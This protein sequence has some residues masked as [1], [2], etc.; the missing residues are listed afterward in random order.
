MMNYEFDKKI[1]LVCKYYELEFKNYYKDNKNILVKTFSAQCRNKTGK[2][3]SCYD[4]SRFEHIYFGTCFLGV[5]DY[6]VSH[7]KVCLSWVLSEEE[8]KRFIKIGSYI[9]SG[10]WLK[11]WREVIIT[12]YKFDQK[13]AELFFN[14]YFKTIVFLDTVPYSGSKKDLYEFSEFVNLPFSIHNMSYFSI[15]I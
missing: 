11:Y 6:N 2:S 15:D 1:V 7:N 3:I 10:G 9:V 14:E 12:E 13:G 8:L 5:N 4:T